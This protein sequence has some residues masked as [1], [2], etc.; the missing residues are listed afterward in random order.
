MYER[1]AVLTAA[2]PLINVET[3]LIEAL[4]SARTDC[5]RQEYDGGGRRAKHCP[6]LPTTPRYEPDRLLNHALYTDALPGSIIK[7]IMAAGLLREPSYRRKVL[8]DRVAA[9]FI[10]LQDELKGSDS[11]AFLNR[12]FWADKAWANCDRPREIQQAALLLGW[13]AGCDEASFRCGRLNV[14]FGYA[15]GK[16]IRKDAARTPL[17]SSILYG[18]LLTEPAGRAR[19]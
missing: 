16:R 3:G 18:R 17:G 7:P 11:I 15:D 5:Y 4:G 14:L 6:D 9:D 19:P 12:M 2:I 13:N 8:A 10:R 1:T